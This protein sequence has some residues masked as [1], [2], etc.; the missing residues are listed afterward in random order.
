MQLAV[1]FKLLVLSRMQYKVD[2]AES[3]GHQTVLDLC[4]DAAGHRD[5]IKCQQDDFGKN[6]KHVDRHRAR[7]LTTA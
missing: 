4:Q 6:Y 2:K 1:F 3:N 7:Q 5:C